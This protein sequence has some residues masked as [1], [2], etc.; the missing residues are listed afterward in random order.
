MGGF[1][2][3]DREAR[4]IYSFEAK[5]K[6]DN[7]LGLATLFGRVVISAATGRWI[8]R[9]FFPKLRSESVT[10]LIGITFWVVMASLPYLWPLVVA[11]LLVTS[12]GLALTARYRLSWKKSES[13]KV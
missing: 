6:D 13:A 1:T 3:K 11:G 4:L 7:R 8:Q 12:L 9:R 2:Y 10:L 5:A